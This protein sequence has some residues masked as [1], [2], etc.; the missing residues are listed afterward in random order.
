[1]AAKSPRF[2]ASGT[3]EQLDRN[4]FID[5]GQHAITEKPFLVNKKCFIQSKEKK[6]KDY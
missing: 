3:L 6:L 1:M 2:T 4:T 5:F